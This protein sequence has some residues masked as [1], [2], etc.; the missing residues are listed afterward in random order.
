MTNSLKLILNRGA[1]DNVNTCNETVAFVYAF[2][3]FQPSF[4][5]TLHTFLCQQ[6]SLQDE[7]TLI[8][9]PPGGALTSN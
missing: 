1:L 7:T 4:E 9:H 6:I 5:E 2:K 8:C 3:L